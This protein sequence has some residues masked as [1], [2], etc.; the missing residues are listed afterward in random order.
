M[1][2]ALGVS[3][4]V[5]PVIWTS[6]ALTVI[7]GVLVWAGFIAWGAYFTVGKDAL[8]KLSLIHI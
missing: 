2:N 3:S 5:T 4:G 6:L 8:S 1:K 7:P